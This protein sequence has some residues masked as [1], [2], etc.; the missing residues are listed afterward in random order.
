MASVNVT[1][2][3]G[4]QRIIEARPGTSLM[5]ALRDQDVGIPAICGGYCSCATCHVYLDADWARKLSPPGSD[6][7]ELIASM[8]VA[9]PGLS[10]LSCQIRVTDD[11]DGIR[12]TIPDKD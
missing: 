5:E 4:E 8:T 10:R 12:L 3:T 11:L 9:R 7:A 1:T 6:E 2:K